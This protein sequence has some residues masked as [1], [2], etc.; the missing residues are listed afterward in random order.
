MRVGSGR[1]GAGRAGGAAPASEPNGAA[2]RRLGV[3]PPVFANLTELDK[4]GELGGQRLRNT[5]RGGIGER[6]DGDVRL[7][8]DHEFVAAPSANAPE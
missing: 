1:D 4:V 8:D 6:D 7:R 2:F 3:E 5:R